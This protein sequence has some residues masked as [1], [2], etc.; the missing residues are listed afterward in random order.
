MLSM[1]GLLLRLLVVRRR[2]MAAWAVYLSALAVLN[3]GPTGPVPEAYGP[4]SALLVPVT[5]W[6]VMSGML[7][8][9]GT[10]SMLAAAAGRPR[11]LHRWATLAGALAA[12]PFAV[13]AAVWDLLA[14]PPAVGPWVAK[15]G[16]GLLA[17]LTALMVGAGIGSLASRAVTRDD[18]VAL[19]VGACACLAA[20]GVR[21]STPLWPVLAGMSSLAT[22]QVT[23]PARWWGAVVTLVLWC[24][25]S[26]GWAL[27]LTEGAARAAERRRA[28]GACA[29]P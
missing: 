7:H 25:V 23:D 29:A 13:L 10:A 26:L 1:V 8:D 24:G 19:L 4:T 9:R 3:A 21:W 27:L 15:L 2:S 12:V 5:A 14:A 22:R 6:L 28:Y 18:A 17:H 20:V 11:R 16:V